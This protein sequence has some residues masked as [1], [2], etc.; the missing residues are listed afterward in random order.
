MGVSKG[1]TRSVD[2]SS[3]VDACFPEFFFETCVV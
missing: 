3:L 2:Y 1:E